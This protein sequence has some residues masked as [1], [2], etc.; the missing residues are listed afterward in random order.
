MLNSDQSIPPDEPFEDLGCVDGS[1]KVEAKKTSQAKSEP[2]QAVKEE[3]IIPKK[4]LFLCLNNLF[5]LSIR[6]TLYFKIHHDEQISSNKILSESPPTKVG[7]QESPKSIPGCEKNF[8]S[9][10]LDALLGQIVNKKYFSFS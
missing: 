7:R 2:I 1:P 4:V 8:F 10:N 5:P 3:I 6:L 9:I